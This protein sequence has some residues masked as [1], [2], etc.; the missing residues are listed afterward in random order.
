MSQEYYIEMDRY[1]EL[2]Y[3]KF[4]TVEELEAQY[5]VVLQ[6]IMES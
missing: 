2:K 1:D 5:R 6:I 4:T 3:N